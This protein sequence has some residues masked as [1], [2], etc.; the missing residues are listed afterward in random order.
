MDFIRTIDTFWCL[1]NRVS[2]RLAQGIISRAAHGNA[3]TFAQRFTP[4]NLTRQG[5]RHGHTTAIAG[6]QCAVPR[7]ISPRDCTSFLLVPI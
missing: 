7:E 5:V 4:L 6:V 1:G 3:R 2:S